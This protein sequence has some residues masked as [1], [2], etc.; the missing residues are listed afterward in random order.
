MLYQLVSPWADPEAAMPQIRSL[1]E[2][3]LDALD[4]DERLHEERIATEIGPLA[5]QRQSL[6]RDEFL[7]ICRWKS[8]RPSPR[9]LKNSEEDVREITKAS[10]ASSNERLRI[11]ALTL[12]DGV[13][14]SVAATLLHV[15]HQDRYPMLDVRVV[16]LLTGDGELY[17]RIK[18]A[19]YFSFWNSLTLFT[20]KLSDD[21]GV[22]MRT[23]DRA[24]FQLDVEKNDR[25][26][27]R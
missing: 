8:K 16:R 18:P 19:E 2:R 1:A 3:F 21:C 14:W 13:G 26:P 24:L 23:L 20:R 6:T 25:L 15:C 22:D 7:D 12:L 5:W 11:G 10:F 27:D 4:A 9:Y 17:Y